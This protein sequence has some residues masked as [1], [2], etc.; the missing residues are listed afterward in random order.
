MLP[1]RGCDA[2][3]CIKTSGLLDGSNIH[4]HQGG[5]YGIQRALRSNYKNAFGWNAAPGT[6]RPRQD[7]G[8]SGIRAGVANAEP[9]GSAFSY[10]A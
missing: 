2:R 3:K 4:Q 6:V 7:F 9:A 1:A 8:Y 5:Q 10:G